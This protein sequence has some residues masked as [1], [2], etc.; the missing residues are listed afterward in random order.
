MMAKKKKAE[1]PEELTLD[2]LNRIEDLLQK[3]VLF[4]ACSAGANKAALR[5]W[6]RVRN[7]S[8]AAASKVLKNPK[9]KTKG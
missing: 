1:T 8:I 7:N 6:M 5:K 3:L 4:Q 9:T 2:S